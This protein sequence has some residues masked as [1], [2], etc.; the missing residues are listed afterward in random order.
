MQGGRGHAHTLHGQEAY[1]ISADRLS[2]NS[3]RS[4]AAVL[5]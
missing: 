4:T 1:Y 5:D 3:G 2:N